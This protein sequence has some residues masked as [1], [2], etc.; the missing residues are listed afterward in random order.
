MHSEARHCR[1]TSFQNRQHCLCVLLHPSPILQDIKKLRTE[2]TDVPHARGYHTCF[3][4]ALP[5]VGII[6]K[7]PV[8][9]MLM[10]TNTSRIR[11]T[12][13]STGDAPHFAMASEPG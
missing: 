12:H 13:L 1:H 5:S 11:F 8:F 6:M 4:G 10:F 9:S 7:S 3:L 2:L